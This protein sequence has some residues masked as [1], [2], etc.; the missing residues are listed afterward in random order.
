MS[1][2]KS[3]LSS[4]FSHCANSWFLPCETLQIP[5]PLIRRPILHVNN[6]QLLWETFALLSFSFNICCS[7]LQP[8]R[9]WACGSDSDQ[10]SV[11]QQAEFLDWPSARSLHCNIQLSVLLSE[12]QKRGPS[13]KWFFSLFCRNN[14]K[15]ASLCEKF[16]CWS[17]LETELFIVLTVHHCGLGFNRYDN[18]S[19]IGGAVL[20][21]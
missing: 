21:H 8:S 4:S 16:F 3:H 9:C 18:L 6:F 2:H 13:E 14:K 15:V 1:I 17:L 12:S 5:V 10:D 7:F 11:M 20:L 19:R